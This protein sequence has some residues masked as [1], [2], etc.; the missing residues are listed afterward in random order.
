MAELAAIGMV[1]TRGM[2]ALMEAT[3]AMLKA[4]HVE[5]LGWR[6]VGS[7]LVTM[8]VTGEVAA[9][10]SAL[11][12]GAAAAAKVGEVRAVHV[13]PRPHAELAGLYPPARKPAARK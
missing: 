13:I 4:A 3:D 1:E 5:A 10:K 2:V 8:F 12:A 9:V 11:A 7:G 6:K